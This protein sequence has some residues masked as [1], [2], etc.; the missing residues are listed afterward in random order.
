MGRAKPTRIMV[1]PDAHHPYVDELAWRTFLAAARKVK[2][3]VMV[4]IGDFADCYA[5]SSHAKDPGR[6]SRLKDE[7]EAVNKALDQISRLEIP[8]VEFCEG[9]HETRITRFV[10]SEASALYGM[11]DVKDL[12]RIT[13][14]GWGWTAYNDFLRIGKVAFTHDVGRCGV[15]TARQ[16]LQDFGGNI[17]IGHSHRA[18]LAFQG[19]T[20]GEQHFGLNVGWLG[21]V[22]SIDYHHKARARRDWQHAFGLIDQTADGLSWATLVPILEGRCVVYGEQ[23]SGRARS[24]R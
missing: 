12:L 5:V 21:D 1:C 17:V 19:T 23:V 7:L 4:V 3:D 20:A 6:K 2:P 16:S 13:E 22:D 24:K 11:L 15:N 8:R 10:A 18:S 9:N 14:R